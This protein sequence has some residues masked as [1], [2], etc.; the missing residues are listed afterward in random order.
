MDGDQRETLGVEIGRSLARVG[1]RV[2]RL[3]TAHTLLNLLAVIGG[4]VSTLLAGGSAANGAPLL[5]VGNAGWGLTCALAALLT[6]GGT[7]AGGIDQQFR[8]GET[9]GQARACMGRLRALEVALSTGSVQ[10]AAVAER[11]T[12]LLADCQAVLR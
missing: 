6:L 4:L 12:D 7:L 9:L 1:E 11:Y 8:V 5:G 10:P 2:S 3:Q